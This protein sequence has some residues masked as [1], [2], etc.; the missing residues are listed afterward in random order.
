MR[1]TEP[2]VGRMFSDVQ[3]DAVKAKNDDYNP[4]NAL[5]ENEAEAFK[6][7]W[8]AFWHVANVM[9]FSEYFHAIGD[10]ASQRFAEYS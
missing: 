5:D 10:A 1:T 4:L 9:Q 3:R 2:H 7:Q 8:A 6:T